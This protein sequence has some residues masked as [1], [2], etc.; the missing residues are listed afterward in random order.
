MKKY[1]IAIDVAP[2]E[3]LVGDDKKLE[4]MAM[5]FGLKSPL[6]LLRKLGPNFQTKKTD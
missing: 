1:V 6:S 4:V 5:V 2:S 3:Q